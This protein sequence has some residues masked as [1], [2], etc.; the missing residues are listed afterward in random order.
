MTKFLVIEHTHHPS[1]GSPR[2]FY[3]VFDTKDMAQKFID[4]SRTMG[5]TTPGSYSY[6]E[7]ILYNPIVVK[8]D[9]KEPFP[10]E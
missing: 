2:E 6:I 10:S 1:D 4:D 5:H 7:K 9:A 8:L 3:Y